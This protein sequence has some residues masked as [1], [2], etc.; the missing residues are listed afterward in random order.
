MLVES[1]L[2]YST[3]LARPHILA[4][5]VGFVL[6]FTPMS[7]VTQNQ[8]Q[9]PAA[10]APALTLV[11]GFVGG[12]VH[13]DDSRHSEVQ[14]SRR[15][16]AKYGSGVQVEVFKNR[17]KEKARKAILNWF[18]LLEVASAT[19]NQRPEASL[20]LFGHSWGGSAVIYLARELEKEGVPVT[21]TIQVDSVRKHGQ[22]DS[23][24]PSNVAEAVNFYQTKGIIHGRPEIVAAD[25]HRTAVLGNFRFDYA[26]EPAE[27]SVYPWYDRF[28]FKGHTSIECDPRVWS[29]IQ[30]LIVSHLAPRVNPGQFEVAAGLVK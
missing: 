19:T 12:F 7:G 6:L 2:D 18:N 27:C 28:F 21:L 14:L 16:Q 15:L 25:P 11:V 1:I 26:K 30:G 29:S 9:E 3:R 20:I 17:D 24:I 22:D 8:R 23:V 10:T 4:Q 13:T 5:F